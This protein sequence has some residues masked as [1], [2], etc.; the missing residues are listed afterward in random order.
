QRNAMLMYTSCGW[1]FDEI[2]GIETVQVLQYACRAI[3]LSQELSGLSPEPLFLTYLEAAP[4]NI[5]EFENGA[6][7][8]RM[9]ARPASVDFLRLGAH[10]AIS[11]LFDEYPEKIKIYCYC[12][13]ADIFTKKQSGQFKLFICR[14]HLSSDVTGEE[15]RF[16]SAAL[17]LG[18]HNINCGVR[19]FISSEASDRMH[20][21]I[22]ESFDR[23]NI[24]EVLKYMES[25]FGTHNYS[26]EDLFKDEQRNLLN[27]I[28]QPTFDAIDA[29]LAQVCDNNCLII[30]FYNSVHV[31]VPRK[32][33]SV[34]S[35][36]ANSDLERSLTQELRIDEFRK[37]VEET[38][39][40][41]LDI[42]RA[43]VAFLGSA[44][45]DRRMESIEK[46]HDDVSLIEKTGAVLG[47]LNS[48]SI[49][50]NLWKAQNIYFRIDS[51][52]HANR[53]KEVPAVGEK[54]LSQG[55]V[56]AFHKLGEGLNIK[57][58]NLP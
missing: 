40:W 49:P 42:D 58:Q 4:T 5:P 38:K 55:W 16:S 54:A 51:R 32:L 21:E 9:F 14:A 22:A 10:Y 26:I 43:K 37:L 31:P 20:R 48:V 30:D 7:I 19:T 50:L 6:G 13:N 12:A 2:S 41:S 17:H 44:W 53:N 47:L 15:A 45:I 36:R 34:I 28:V 8:Y 11:A 27:K 39:R 18:D 25:N 35:Y 1:F 3:Q 33:L 23:G 57:E 52:L 29:S 56:A 24:L 46:A